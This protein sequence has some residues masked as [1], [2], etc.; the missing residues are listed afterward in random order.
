MGKEMVVCRDVKKFDVKSLMHGWL[1]T[2]A[3][4]DFDHT[5]LPF[6]YFS[7]FSGNVDPLTKIPESSS[8]PTR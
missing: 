7:K 1:Y 6:S 4:L 5:T 2:T 8:V 3:K